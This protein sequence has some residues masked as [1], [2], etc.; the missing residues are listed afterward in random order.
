MPPQSPRPSD[1]TGGAR[2]RAGSRITS[3]AGSHLASRTGSRPTSAE[4]VQALRS[5]PFMTD[6]SEKASQLR[7][8]SIR[9]PTLERHEEAVEVRFKNVCRIIGL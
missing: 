8:M 3:R 1:A 2:S 7:R 9:R 4:F 5:E 6:A